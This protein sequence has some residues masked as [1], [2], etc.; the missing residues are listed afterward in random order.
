MHYHYYIVQYYSYCRFDLHIFAISNR[1]W[2]YDYRYA[3]M[4]KKH[5]LGTCITI[6]YHYHYPSVLHYA[7]VITYSIHTPK[8]IYMHHCAISMVR[9][10]RIWKKTPTPTTYYQ[11]Y[12]SDD[13]SMKLLHN[14]SSL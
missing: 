10:Y 12:M 9:E 13:C 14:N 11:R 4:A 6:N 1:S 2:R 7:Y 5:R 8:C 3:V